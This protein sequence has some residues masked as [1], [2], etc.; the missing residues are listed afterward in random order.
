MRRQRAN[1]RHEDIGQ[2]LGPRADVELVDRTVARRLNRLAVAPREPAAEALAR[3][4]LPA[5]VDPPRGATRRAHADETQDVVGPAETTRP[6]GGRWEASEV[7]E[8]PRELDYVCARIPQ[9]VTNRAM[10][11][12][13]QDVHLLG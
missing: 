1:D 2:G 8:P 5:H 12:S 4:R 9:A 7:V 6:P 11:Q 3:Q 13:G 10:R